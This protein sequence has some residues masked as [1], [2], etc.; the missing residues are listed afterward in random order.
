MF[1]AQ[2]AIRAQ[3][4]VRQWLVRSKLYDELNAQGYQ[5]KTEILKSKLIA[6]KLE[7]V[8]AK[9]STYMNKKNR[10][11]QETLV[12]AEELKS[13]HESLMQDYEKNYEAIM[14]KRMNRN[15]EQV[16]KLP[17][18]VQQSTHSPVQ[19]NP[20]IEGVK[21]RLGEPCS[22][23]LCELNTD[24]PMLATS[25]GH[26]FHALCLVNFESFA[27][28]PTKRCPNCRHSNYTHQPFV[29]NQHV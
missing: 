25:C 12:R 13:K 1:I 14:H 11:I 3:S 26:L 21:K 9:M 24:K 15:A 28:N 23:C 27:P 5:P 18:V 17:T 4:L 7:R 6:H 2:S 20:V 10:L 16:K 22:I 29:S 19:A 8:V